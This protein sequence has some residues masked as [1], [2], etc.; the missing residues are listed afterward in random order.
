M[1]RFVSL[2]S[3]AVMATACVSKPPPAPVKCMETVREYVSKKKAEGQVVQ[4]RP[5]QYGGGIVMAS[6]D[7][8][9]IEFLAF[10]APAEV[11]EIVET[12]SA[13]DKSSAKVTGKCLHDEIG[14]EY[15]LVEGKLHQAPEK[16]QAQ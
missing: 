14:A 10:V 9:D 2:V 4:G 13:R 11:T 1:Y 15:V 5:L 8:V 7:F 16:A 6:R 3:L 12:V